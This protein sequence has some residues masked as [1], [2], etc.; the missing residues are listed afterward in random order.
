MGQKTHPTG[1]RLGIIGDWNSK[2]FASKNYADWASLPMMS[3]KS[4]AS[5]TRLA[6]SSSS[7][8]FIFPALTLRMS[9]RAPAAHL[10]R[11]GRK[12][13]AGQSFGPFPVRSMRLL[14]EAVG[15]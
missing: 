11:D 9:G 2:W 13:S 7:F 8:S 4:C 12:P 15:D 6:K 14:S 1:F 3:T 10:A 5:S